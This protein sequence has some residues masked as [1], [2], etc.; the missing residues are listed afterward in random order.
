[1]SY[2]HQDFLGVSAQRYEDL[3]ADCASCFGLCCVAFYFSA[4]DGFPADKAA[5]HPCINLQPDFR[6]GIHKTLTEQGFKGC[7]TYDCF[8][9]GQKVSEVSFKGQDWR[10]N[11]QAVRKMFQ[12]FLVMEQLQELLWY[13][14]EAQAI[15]MTGSFASEISA[16]HGLTEK[17]T[18]LNPDA[19]ISLNVAEHRT[20]VDALLQK[21]SEMVRA[22]AAR[23][24]RRNLK[25]H[26]K[27]SPRADL[28][29]ADLKHTDLY[30]ANLRGAL[31]I[32]ADLRDNE[33]V[34]TDVIGADF[35]DADIRGANLAASLFLTQAQV[36]SA[37]GD[38]NTKLPAWL[39][40]PAHWKA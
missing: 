8:G 13:L 7:T 21:T 6:C 16:M 15:P 1:M 17:L 11:T 14:S 34:G 23:Q 26:K 18:F 19:L 10:K 37:K 5:G 35:R 38:R 27:T 28:M 12:V 36:N 32:A 3:R 33:L 25:K 9:A 31:L 30:G 29:A 24:N 2:I 39:I 4:I 22:A 40:R 20:K